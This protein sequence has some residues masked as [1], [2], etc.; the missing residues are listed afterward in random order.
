M[1]NRNFT[2]FNRIP[3]QHPLFLGPRRGSPYFQSMRCGFPLF[4][5]TTWNDKC[6]QRHHHHNYQQNDHHQRHHD[7]NIKGNPGEGSGRFRLCPEASHEDA[8]LLKCFHIQS[9]IIKQYWA[10]LNLV[11]K[12]LFAMLL[13]DHLKHLPDSMIQF[14]LR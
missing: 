9:D 6:N 10:C 3:F 8:A 2:V 12:N 7:H 4:V 11:A 14:P 1:F 5:V 13:R